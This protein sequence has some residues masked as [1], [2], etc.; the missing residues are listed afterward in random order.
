MVL[1]RYVKNF[2]YLNFTLYL[3]ILT[4]SHILGGGNFP[5]CEYGVHWIVIENVVE[6]DTFTTATM[7]NLLN[8]NANPNGN[9]KMLYEMKDKD[10]LYVRIPN[11]ANQ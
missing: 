7:R 10:L 11:F 4:H 3:S 2:G 8:K 6:V 5:K 1:Y 9:A